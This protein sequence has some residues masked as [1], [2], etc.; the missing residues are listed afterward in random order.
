VLGRLLPAGHFTAALPR[1]DEGARRV[2]SLALP[3]PRPGAYRFRVQTRQGGR[4]LDENGF[5]FRIGAEPA[6]AH[7][8]RRVPGF[9][10]NRVYQTG[11]LRHTA[12]GFT[13]ALRNPTTPVTLQ[14]LADF[15]VDGQPISAGQVDL[16]LGAVT[17]QVSTI[18][19]QAPFD[20]PSGERLTIVVHGRLL[21][22]GAHELELTLH[23]LGFGELAARLKD[24]LV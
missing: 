21:P 3:A 16:V 17:R 8:V 5:D 18:T 20:L 24:H 9:L 14:G 12:E 11:S 6:A 4:L 15:K 22:P 13:F 10:I 2:Q 7:T 19:P 1:A 23:V